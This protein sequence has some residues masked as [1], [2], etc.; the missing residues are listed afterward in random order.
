MRDLY[1][2]EDAELDYLDA[3]NAYQGAGWQFTVERLSGEWVA[4]CSLTPSL[5][6]R[7]PTKA[8]AIILCLAATVANLAEGLALETGRPLAPIVCS[9]CKATFGSHA[10]AFRHMKATHAQRWRC[11]KCGGEAK[12]TIVRAEQAGCINCATPMERVG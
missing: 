6:T 8:E 11:P 3:L 10:D 2:D 12:F 4:R 7:A 9:Y 5:V 1:N